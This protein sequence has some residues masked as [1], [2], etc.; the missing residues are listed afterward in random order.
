MSDSHDKDI[1]IKDLLPEGTLTPEEKEKL[2]R[3]G[4]F[5]FR[6]TFDALEAREMMNAAPI[7]SLQPPPAHDQPGNMRTEAAPP[8]STNTPARSLDNTS[9]TNDRWANQGKV[10]FNEGF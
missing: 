8:A 7:V 5:S 9:W 2:A 3:A 6:P 1:E 4:R 10:I